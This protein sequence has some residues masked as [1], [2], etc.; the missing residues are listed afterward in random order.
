MADAGIPPRD[1]QAI[2]RHA[3]LAT[4]EKYYL[5]HRASEQADRIAS[6]LD[7]SRNGCTH[8]STGTPESADEKRTHIEST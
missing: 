3:S 5:R 4:T 2:M 6:Y 8:F 1:L 7:G